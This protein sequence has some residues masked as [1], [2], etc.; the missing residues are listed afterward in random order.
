MESEALAW[1]RASCTRLSFML[2]Y[3]L[4]TSD[5]QVSV[6]PH[7]RMSG[8]LSLCMSVPPSLCLSV[9]PSLC[10]SVSLYVCPS[11]SLY[12]CPSASLS[13]CLSVSL[14]LLSFVSC[15]PASLSLCLSVSL[16]LCL[17]KTCVCLRVRLRKHEFTKVRISAQL[18]QLRGR[19]RHM[20]VCHLQ[21]AVARRSFFRPRQGVWNR[22]GNVV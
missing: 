9:S 21:G 11:V 6:R 14:S 2:K 18:T 7:A 15:L 5:A 12:V 4:I 17:C 20:A 1:T 16:S 13:L 19:G 10:L 22:V 8:R 3:S